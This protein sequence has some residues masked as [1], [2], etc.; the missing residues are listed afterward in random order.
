M[1]KSCNSVKLFQL[2]FSAILL[3]LL[4]R[5]FA[6]D[7]IHHQDPQIY[8]LDKLVTHNI[9]FLGTRHRQPPNLKFIAD[10]IPKLH[11]SGVTHIG[12][13]I[14]SDQQSKVDKFAQTG[15][16]L[17]TIN[18]HPQIDCLEFRNLF[19]VLKSL[20][21]DKRST[22]VALDLPKSKYQENISRS[23]WMAKTIAKIF[24]QDPT[25]KMIVVVGNNHVL[26]K[27]EWQDHVPNPH[28]SMRE[29]LL[30]SNPD[31]R[32]FSIGQIIGDTVY[33]CDFREA[34][35]GLEGAV[36]ID[37]DQ[38]FAGWKMGIAESVAIKPAE[39]WELLDGLIV[40]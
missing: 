4:E 19:K 36:A 40:Y 10:L 6:A 33:E 21:P 24:M 8:A 26:K 37:L 32:M 38:R 15:N 16:N 18:I 25:A 2:I 28:R 34:F 9:V 3:L 23:E 29:Y 27:L 22:P 17:S 35:G 7:I 20:N 31:L 39:L 1:D 12:L 14:E 30:E 13:E 11:N 5:S